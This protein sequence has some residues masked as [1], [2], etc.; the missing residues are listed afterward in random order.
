MH[1]NSGFLAVGTLAIVLLFFG[2]RS[3]D[4]E[5][6][7]NPLRTP[8]PMRVEFDGGNIRTVTVSAQR[9]GHFLLDTEI[10]GRKTPMLVDTGAS[11][12]T[13]RESDARKAGLR[14][15]RRDFSIPFSTANGRV[16]AAQGAL[17]ELRIGPAVLR[18]LQI[19][20]LPDD[21]L[22]TSLFG[23]NGLNRFARRQTTADTLT[24]YTE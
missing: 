8:P 1:G 3:F 7:F 18:D 16:L 17:P 4:D 9:D 19:V 23:V 22:E 14:F 21:K 13:L 10:A 20:V 11:I 24:L 15:T 5:G 6:R 12:V 2:L